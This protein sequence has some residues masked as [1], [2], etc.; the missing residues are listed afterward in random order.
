VNAPGNSSSSRLR[1]ESSFFRRSR[2]ES[3]HA[4]SCGARWCVCPTSGLS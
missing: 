1:S 2:A 3:S 4:E